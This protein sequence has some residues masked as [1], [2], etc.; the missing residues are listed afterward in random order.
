MLLAGVFRGLLVGVVAG[1]HERAGFD[2]AQADAEGELLPVPELLGRHPAVDLPVLR[3][4]LQVLAEREDVHL[5]GGDVAQALFDLGRRLAE[6][7][8]DSGLRGEA[9]RLGVAEHGEAAL[10][11]GLHADGLLEA[12]DGLD[13]VVE[14][15]GLGVEHGVEVV[16]AALPVGGEHLDGALRVAVLGGA[17]G[18][19]PD[20]G[21]AVL[22]VVAGDGGDDAVAEAHLGDG[23]G[24]AGGL[25]Q[26][27]LGGAAGLDRAEIAGARADVAE[28]HHRGRAAGPA[29][30]NS[31]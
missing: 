2:D 28:D 8:H 16:G 6:A 15:V 3:G 22:Q 29:P 5:L 7:E 21:A 19:G 30:P 11:A 12:L 31:R 20:A 9:A 27:E 24:D 10:V 4:G 25:A 13:V 26:I 17:D 14:D 23:V 18:G 1:A